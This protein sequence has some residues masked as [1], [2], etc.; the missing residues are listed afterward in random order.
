M[1]YSALKPPRFRGAV[2]FNESVF[3]SPY[4]QPEWAR[5][6]EGSVRAVASGVWRRPDAARTCL[7][8]APDVPQTS[9]RRR[10][11][12]AAGRKL[13]SRGTPDGRRTRHQTAPAADASAGRESGRGRTP[14]PD[15][16]MQPSVR[17]PEGD[18]AGL[19]RRSLRTKGLSVPRAGLPT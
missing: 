3:V 4:P 5:R 1:A 15:F 14:S 18:R 8:R 9:P 2:F 16:R 10:A 7:G 11:P 12:D 19:R 17:A 13:K 6:T